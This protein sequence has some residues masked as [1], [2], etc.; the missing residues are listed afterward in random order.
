MPAPVTLTPA[1]SSANSQNPNSGKARPR[2]LGTR[3][4]RT[5]TRIGA[6]NS[7]TSKLTILHVDPAS[8]KRSRRPGHNTPDA[9]LD[10]AEVIARGVRTRAQVRAASAKITLP[11][12]AR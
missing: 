11:G 12:D 3:T 9:T 6:P 2:T 1:R 4:L 10:R 5:R 8:L 7:G